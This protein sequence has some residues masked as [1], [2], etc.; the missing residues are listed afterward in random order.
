MLHAANW[1]LMNCSKLLDFKY[2]QPVE[3]K[4]SDIAEEP[5]ERGPQGFERAQSLS[6][7]V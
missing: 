2:A 7:V 5:K 3:F 1:V 4:G 6:S